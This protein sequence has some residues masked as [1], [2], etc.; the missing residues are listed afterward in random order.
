M[1]ILEF[2]STGRT[3]ETVDIGAGYQLLVS[4]IGGA[5]LDGTATVQDLNDLRTYDLPDGQQAQTWP[6]NGPM[7]LAFIA[8]S[9]PG[10]LEVIAQEA[11]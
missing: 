10:I 1:A 4:R 6:A 7:R 5:P 2:D 8:R 9:N 3:Y 11:M